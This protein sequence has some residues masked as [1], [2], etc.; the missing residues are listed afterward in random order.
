MSTVDHRRICMV[1]AVAVAVSI[2]HYVDNVA[3]YDRY[4]ESA[5]LPNPSAAIVG[6]SWFLFT[7]FGLAAVV[8]LQRG[9]V[10]R[11]AVCLAV[12]SGSGLVGILHYTVGGTS[13]FPW[14]RHAH[15]V[16]DIILGLVIFALAMQ[17]ARH[18]RLPPAA[19]A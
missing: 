14:W 10:R 15:I 18:R 5:T 6:G 3:A 7:A 12:Y 2:V 13:A 16:A 9:E 4:P 17:L 1:L 8:L 11:A 19:A